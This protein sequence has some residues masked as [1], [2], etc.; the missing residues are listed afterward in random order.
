MLLALYECLPFD[1]REDGHSVMAPVDDISLSVISF[2][3]SLNFD[4]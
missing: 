3:W 1:V 4:V 2:L